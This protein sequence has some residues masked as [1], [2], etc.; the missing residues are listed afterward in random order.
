MVK[1]KDL[2]RDHTHRIVIAKPVN[3]KFGQEVGVGA[4]CSFPN[5]ENYLIIST[6]F[7]RLKVFG[8]TKDC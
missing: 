4:I 7:R 2:L 1:I 6:I 3:L 8:G 5:K